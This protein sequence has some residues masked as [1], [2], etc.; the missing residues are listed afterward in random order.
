MH[1]ERQGHRQLQQV[2]PFQTCD[3]LEAAKLAHE[4]HAASQEKR[5]GTDS[6]GAA[7]WEARRVLVLI[8]S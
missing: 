1:K 8:G 3:M 4:L 5:G 6:V 2:Q 7:E